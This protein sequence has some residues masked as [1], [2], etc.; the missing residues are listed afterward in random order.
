MKGSLELVSQEVR[1]KPAWLCGGSNPEWAS[2]CA[3]QHSAGG[4]LAR[5]G[6]RAESRQHYVIRRGEPAQLAVFT[7]SE[8]GLR[9][10]FLVPRSSPRGAEL[11]GTTLAGRQLLRLRCR[12]D[13]D[14]ERLLRGHAESVGRLE[15]HAV[16]ARACRDAEESAGRAVEANA[17]RERPA[18]DPPRRRLDSAERR[19][20]GR[21]ELADLAGAKQKRRDSQLGGDD[22]GRRIVR[23]ARL[24]VG[25]GRGEPVDACGRRRSRRSRRQPG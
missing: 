16:A 24:R 13:E 2:F 11:G 18:E 14:R 8:R 15:R 3:P 19:D 12:D 6:V 10:V 20:L 22:D 17:S 1:R 5:A 21:I 9:G 23:D 4:S 25:G 7:F